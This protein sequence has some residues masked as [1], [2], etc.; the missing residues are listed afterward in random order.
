MENKP[1]MKKRILWSAC[2]RLW[3]RGV[4]FFRFRSWSEY[5]FKPRYFSR[6]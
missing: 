5:Q 4:S 1:G 6:R 2:F 3:R